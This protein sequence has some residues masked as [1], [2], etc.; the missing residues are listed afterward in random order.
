MSVAYTDP[1]GVTDVDVTDAPASGQTVTGHGGMIP[2]RFKLKYLGV[3]R[4]VYAMAYGNGSV[5]YV[6][7]KGSTVVLDAGTQSLLEGN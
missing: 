7:V 5:P 4:R 1:E 2:T 6:R 3:W